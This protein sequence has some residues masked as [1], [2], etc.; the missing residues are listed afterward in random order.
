MVVLFNLGF[1]L[2]CTTN[3]ECDDGI[4]CT[5]DICHNQ[6][7]LIR[8]TCNHDF[9]TDTPRFPFLSVNAFKCNPNADKCMIYNPRPSYDLPL[10]S[11]E[12]NDNTIGCF[13]FVPS[14]EGNYHSYGMC[15]TS[16]TTCSSGQYCDPISNSC[17]SDIVCTNNLNCTDNLYCN[18]VET[19]DF[20]TGVCLPGIPPSCDD[21]ISCTIDLCYEN[22]DNCANPPICGQGEFC[23]WTSSQCESVEDCTPLCIGKEC[24][25]DGCGGSCGSCIGGET[26]NIGTGQCVASCTPSCIGKDCGD[27]GCGGSCGTCVGGQTCNLTSGSCGAIVISGCSVDIDCN[28]GIICTDEI[29][30]LNNQCSYI[31]NCQSG[32]VCNPSL[33]QCSDP[34]LCG[35]NSDC[36]DGLWCNGIEQCITGNCIAGFVPDCDDNITC[37]TETCDELNRRCVRTDN[38]LF[39]ENCDMVADMCVAGDAC[40]VDLDCDDGIDC[41]LDVCDRVSG[42]CSYA[43]DC[44]DGEIC[45]IVLGSCFNLFEDDMLDSNGVPSGLSGGFGSNSGLGFEDSPGPSDFLDPFEDKLATM[46]PE[47]KNNKII[48]LLVI[49]FILIGVIGTSFYMI[50][51]EKNWSLRGGDENMGMIKQGDPF[52]VVKTSLQP[53]NQ[54]VQQD[55]GVQPSLGVQSVQTS[56]GV[57][58]AANPAV[59][60]GVQ[61][62]LPVANQFTQPSQSIQPNNVNN[63]RKTE[64]Y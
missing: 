50:N 8:D 47:D 11:N 21:G 16:D 55:Q 13:D 33:N 17:K 18:G 1:V 61:P 5:Y 41:T 42:G 10:C 59:Q 63:M 20:S 35:Q 48:F 64:G 53:T 30:G 62:I 23:N 28:D 52:V 49:S 32:L 60:S 6:E 22:D 9:V 4:S 3:A 27:N 45:D 57:Q 12:N 14:I 51:N 26:C 15:V 25:D 7:C 29:C 46:S 36:S 43:D 58:L 40:M 37:T 56:Q 39:G 54:S 34:L 24:G 38:C 31:D 19:C 2:S 44:L